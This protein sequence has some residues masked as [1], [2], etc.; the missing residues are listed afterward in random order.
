MGRKLRKFINNPKSFFND[1][2]IKRSNQMQVI[3][4][5]KISGYSKY[6]VV[7]AVYNV[8]KYLED[9]FESIIRQRLD[10]K[11]NIKLIMVDDGSTDKSAQIIKH[12][13]DKFPKN[14]IYLSKENG[15]Q[16]SARNFGLEYVDSEWVTFIDPDDFVD[17][18]YFFEVDRF[19][20]S[21]KGKNIKLVCCNIIFY[22]EAVNKYSDSHP[23]KYRFSRGDIVLPANN[24]GKYLQLSAATAFFNLKEIAENGLCF[25]I[26]VRPT[27]EDAQLIGKYL[28]A[29]SDGYVCFLSKAHYYYRKRSD[30]TSTLDVAQKQADL[31]DAVL[32]HGCLS[33]LKSFRK[34]CD[35]VPVHIQRTVLYHI[36]WYIKRLVNNAESV[37]FLSESQTAR[38]KHLLQILF[39]YIEADTVINFE[40]AGCWF[41][42]KVGILDYFKKMAP[43]FQICYLERF[44]EYKSQLQ[45][46]YYTNEIGFESFLIDGVDTLPIYSK[47]VQH[48]F[49]GGVFVL[50]RRIWLPLPAEI[51]CKKLRVRI[52]SYEARISLAGKHFAEGVS[53]PMVVSRLSCKITANSTASMYKNA[54]IIMDRDSQADDNAEHLYRYIH[55]NHPEQN[56]Y[57]VLSRESHD[58]SRLENEGFK[59]LPFGSAEY[60]IALREC[61]KI[62]SSHADDYIMNYFGDNSLRGKQ[63]IFLQHGV[64]KDD[65]SVWLN[66]KYRIDCFVTSSL[67]EYKSITDNGSRYKFTSKEVKLTGLP[68]HDALLKSEC[69]SKRLILVMPTWRKHLVGSVIKGNKREINLDF[70]QS[71]Y[72]KAWSSFLCDNRLS[73]IANI[74]DYKITFFPHANV[75]PYLNMFY[76]PEYIEVLDHSKTRIQD[77]FLQSA[78]MVTDYSSVAFE[79]AFLKKPVLYY[80]FD[81]DSIYSGDHF[82][83][84]GYFDY[85]RDGFGP[86]VKDLQML[87]KELEIIL[88][89]GAVPEAEYLERMVQ[90]F[91]YR[92]GKNCERVYQEIISLDKAETADF[93][94]NILLSYAFAATKA[95]EWL[96]ASGRWQR[97]LDLQENTDPTNAEIAR[98]ELVY[99]LKHLASAYDDF[100]SERFRN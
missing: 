84:K 2:W 12:W 28:A 32:Y 46:Y 52:G 49:L 39:N 71:E 94:V 90:F 64:I 86:V 7:S 96:L 92:D 87:F 10:F 100:E 33:I 35:V 4:P 99:A 19:L 11:N 80:Q 42:Y 26:R 53:L 9:F 40:L 22:R 24:L 61:S 21:A 56:I 31:Y 70:M 17:R 8:E 37:S 20:R 18:N 57:F 58:W 66:K 16:A 41:Y 82:Y 55:Q 34:Q 38:F 91:P 65:L 77:L 50:E 29:L 62:I 47:T 63:F 14:I 85:H 25:D 59:L 3:L 93:D 54:F 48:D 74:Y 95:G 43:P 69:S 6:T 30:R 5:K 76:I 1:L 88:K 83:Q 78:L 27:F 13:R 98:R 68:R 75:Q 60:E 73:E 15:G 97:Y 44:D 89:R 51:K 81:E 72:A 36:V 45:L 67:A 79:M 23:L